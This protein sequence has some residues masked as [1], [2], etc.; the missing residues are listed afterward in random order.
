MACARYRDR[1]TDAALAADDVARADAEL[2]AHL[3]ACP[4]CRKEFETQKQLSEAILNGIEAG[5][6]AEPSP[7]FPARVRA[8]L[9]EEQIWARPW[10]SGWVPIAAGALAVIAL[11][12]FVARRGLHPPG[13]R[14]EVR[15]TPGLE[16]QRT[17]EVTPR[18]GGGS[19]NVHSRPSRQVADRG[20][21]RAV[22]A[23]AASEPEVLVPP[24]QHEA[25]LRFYRVV[26]DGRAD[27]ASLLAVPAPLRPAELKIAPLE[28]ASLDS[29]NRS[30]ERN[31]RP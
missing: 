22:R 18:Q 31:D 8:R 2:D 6:N 20:G 30:S 11:A 7:E 14:D 13:P 15:V 12:G 23:A 26:W 16:K 28:V 17:A 19:G 27:A 5:L 3:A 21:P 4:A 10:F 9:V 1:I 29:R 25:V 24:G